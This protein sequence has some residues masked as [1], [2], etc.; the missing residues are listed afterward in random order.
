VPGDRPVT[1]QLVL[2]HAA[3]M[4]VVLG[5]LTG[6]SLTLYDAHCWLVPGLMSKIALVA[7]AEPGSMGS[8]EGSLQHRREW[9]RGNP[10]CCAAQSCRQAV[11]QDQ[12]CLRTWEAEEGGPLES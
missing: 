12:R 2:V 11:G 8:M 5:G 10:V 1:R 6:H 9:K 3:N 4:Q 7:V